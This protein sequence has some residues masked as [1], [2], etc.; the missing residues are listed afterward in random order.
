MILSP[1]QADTRLIYTL[2]STYLPG[3]LALRPQVDHVELPRVTLPPLVSSHDNDLLKRL[4]SGFIRL[5]QRSA[6]LRSRNQHSLV[7]TMRRL[8]QT[9]RMDV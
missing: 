1:L 7:E 2:S 5:E 9:L 4:L 3:K 8:C 6:V